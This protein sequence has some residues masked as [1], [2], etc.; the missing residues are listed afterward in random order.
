MKEKRSCRR[1]RH[2]TSKKSSKRGIPI[3][4]KPRSRRTSRRSSGN[5]EKTK[6]ETIAV[7][8]PARSRTENN[9]FSVTNRSFSRREASPSS[10]NNDLSKRIIQEQ[11]D[12]IQS[13]DGE[14]AEK[15]A[16]VA[17]LTSF[18]PDKSILSVI[19]RSS[20]TGTSRPD[21]PGN[22]DSSQTNIKKERKEQKGTFTPLTVSSIPSVRSDGKKTQYTLLDNPYSSQT[23][24]QSHQT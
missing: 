8:P 2:D 23:N 3:T 9:L 17:P 22:R 13:E 7:A 6:K 10:D 21:P 4:D 19:D 5:H 16:A 12:R 20:G 1:H 14:R 15:I 11:L 18:G 24:I